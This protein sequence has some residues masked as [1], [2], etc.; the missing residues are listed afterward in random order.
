MPEPQPI[1][2]GSISQRMPLFSTKRMPVSAAR[3]S[4]GGRPPFGRG[5]RDGRRGANRD[6]K[7]SETRGVVMCPQV[8]S[9]WSFFYRKGVLLGRLSVSPFAVF[10]HGRK[11][12]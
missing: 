6:Q 5:G 2:R 9:R 1:S 4:V 7:A 3:S 11:G 10:S 12:G 8:A